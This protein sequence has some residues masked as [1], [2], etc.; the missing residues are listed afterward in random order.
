M[1]SAPFDRVLP[2]D[3]H[4]VDA[5]AST[6]KLCGDRLGHEPASCPSR[7]YSSPSSRATWRRSVPPCPR[8]SSCLS[9]QTERAPA[10]CTAA[11]AHVRSPI[12]SGLLATA[13]GSADALPAPLAAFVRDVA[14]TQGRRHPRRAA[15][16]GPL[17]HRHHDEVL[18]PV[19]RGSGRG[20]RQGVHGGLSPTRQDA[21][22]D[23][24]R[25]GAAALRGTLDP[26]GQV[27]G[28]TVAPVRGGGH[29]RRHGRS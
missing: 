10:G 23:T 1:R 14:P 13:T 7:P 9:T 4:D 19:R 3:L 21:R 27:V 11:T 28:S 17:E 20:R 2:R 5:N 12:S 18:A 25:A 22:S 16:S 24:R 26:P 15:A 29:V 6:A 8:R